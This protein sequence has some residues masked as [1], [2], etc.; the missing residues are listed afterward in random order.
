VGL[1]S[2]EAE[3]PFLCLYQRS[4][5]APLVRYFEE[6]YHS[7]FELIAEI[8]TAVAYFQSELAVNSAIRLVYCGKGSV[9]AALKGDLQGLLA[10]R[11][12]ADEPTLFDPLS[13][14][15]LQWEQSV[16]PAGKSIQGPQFTQ[17]VGLAIAAL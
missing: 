13:M 3:V 17:A 10:L 11:N 2:T 15:A 4:A 8:R 9:F 6:Q 14:P 16:L 7:A 12:Q 1:L 5:G